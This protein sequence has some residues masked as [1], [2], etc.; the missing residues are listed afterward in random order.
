MSYPFCLVSDTG[1][2]RENNEDAGQ[3]WPDIHLFAVADGMGGHVAGEVASNV[4]LQTVFDVVAHHRKPRNATQEEE[5]LGA[6]AAAANDAVLREA[7]VRGLDGMGTTLTVARIRNRTVVASH[8][9]DSRLYLIKP[10]EIVQLTKDHNMVALLV[11][12][13]AVARESAHLHPDRHL[14]T[15]AVGTHAEVEPDTLRARI[16]RGARLL[17]S[18]DGLHDVVLD[19]EIFAL[20]RDGDLERAAHAMIEAANR[21]GGPDNITVLLIEP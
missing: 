14:L 20:A 18:S 19:D 9:G 16:P 1:L 3:A 10:D 6:A 2:Q 12:A 21:E 7:D 13:G 17:L 8:V 5:L 4:A 11:E 15:R